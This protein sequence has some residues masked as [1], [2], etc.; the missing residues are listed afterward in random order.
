VESSISSL[1]SVQTGQPSLEP[2]RDSL[3]TRA[4][5]LE[6]WLSLWQRLLR[7]P[8]VRKLSRQKEMPFAT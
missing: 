7:G 5:G 6:A 4:S 8:N 2:R 3:S 1:F